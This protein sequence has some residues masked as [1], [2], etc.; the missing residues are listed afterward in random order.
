M[1]V[2]KMLWPHRWKEPRMNL[3]NTDGRTEE[4]N[5]LTQMVKGSP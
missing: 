3:I 5:R 2:Y 4:E 1:P